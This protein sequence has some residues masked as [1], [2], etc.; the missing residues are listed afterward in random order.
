MHSTFVWLVLPAALG[1]CGCPGVGLLLRGMRSLT[2]DE[3]AKLML[4]AGDGDVT[5][6][7]SEHGLTWK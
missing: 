4:F 3:G 6:P 5:I 1:S 2:I 7:L